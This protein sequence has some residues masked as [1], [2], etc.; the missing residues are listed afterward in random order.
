MKNLI[1]EN[2]ARFYPNQDNRLTLLVSITCINSLTKYRTFLV[3]DRFASI[4]WTERKSLVRAMYHGVWERQRRRSAGARDCCDRGRQSDD[5]DLSTDREDLRCKIRLV[6]YYYYYYT[7]PSRRRS[8]RV[9]DYLLMTPSDG[10]QAGS[11]DPDSSFIWVR[12][13]CTL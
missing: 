1:G 10:R 6:N 2:Y 4:R 13:L 5:G 11:P 9:Q 8:R 12:V 3:C 7:Y